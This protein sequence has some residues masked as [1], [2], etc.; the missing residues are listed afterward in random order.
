M[1]CDVS[2]RFDPCYYLLGCIL[3][4]GTTKIHQVTL[5]VLALARLQFGNVRVWRLHMYCLDEAVSTA[6]SIVEIDLECF[7]QWLL[8]QHPKV[9]TT[10]ENVIVFATRL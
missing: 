5:F 8:S 6:E 2:S 7:L 9:D 3:A 4:H 1:A 10:F